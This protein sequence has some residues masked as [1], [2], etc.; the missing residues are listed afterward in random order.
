MID[1]RSRLD[2]PER[3]L[4]TSDFFVVV[5]SEEDGALTAIR[6]EADVRLETVGE[7]AIERTGG[8]ALIAGRIQMK[9][10]IVS[11]IRVDSLF[12]SIGTT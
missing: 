1:L 9:E 3:A 7:T 2:H 5:R 11:L 4:A 8:D 10:Q 12:R 6:T